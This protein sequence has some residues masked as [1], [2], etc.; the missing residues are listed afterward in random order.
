MSNVNI[1]TVD[2]ER[3]QYEYESK[4]VIFAEII[5]G[6]KK[7]GFKACNIPLKTLKNFNSVPVKAKIEYL[8]EI[9][10]YI[11][12]VEDDNNEFLPCGFISSN[13]STSFLSYSKNIITLKDFRE[14]I[15]FCGLAPEELESE[16]D[17]SLISVHVSSNE[18]TRYLAKISFKN[19]E[20]INVDKFIEIDK[21][22]IKEESLILVKNLFDTVNECLEKYIGGEIFFD[23]LDK[24][25]K[26]DKELLSE[27]LFKTREA[28]PEAKIIASG[29]IGLCLHNFGFDVD[30]IVQGGLRKNKEPLDLSK[31]VNK[32]EK[33]VFIDD[34]YFSGKTSFVVKEALEKVGCIL[35]G[36][37][38]IY[39]GCAEKRK[40]VKSIYRYYD[41]HDL[42]GRKL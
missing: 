27:L 11:L 17:V 24:A 42:L 30:L 41:Y 31:F 33:F 8:E 29:E 19:F 15:D 3:K 10:I 18:D 1:E 13:V 9:D 23:E 37:F 12:K 20:D 21:E 32:G 36:T 4:N 2:K 28:Y 7:M 6:K 40:D 39:D 38:V 34:S 26:F 16:L 35:L 22:N 25:V 5:A 14:I